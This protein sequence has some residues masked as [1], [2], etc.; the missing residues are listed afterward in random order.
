MSNLFDQ[1]PDIGQTIQ[2]TTAVGRFLFVGARVK[3]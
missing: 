1:M 2:P 3:M